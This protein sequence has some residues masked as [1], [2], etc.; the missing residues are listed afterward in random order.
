MRHRDS[1]TGR[2]ARRPEPVEKPKAPTWYRVAVDRGRQRIP[3][4]PWRRSRDDAMKDAIAKE[5]ASYDRGRRE[6]FLAVPVVIE[7]HASFD[8]PPD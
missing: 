8:Q 3:R 1:L 5:L 2:F 7:S 4:G 6:H